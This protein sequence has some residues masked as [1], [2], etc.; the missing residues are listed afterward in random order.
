MAWSRKSRRSNP[1][2]GRADILRP[3]KKMLNI[4]FTLLLILLS[5]PS[6]VLPT[7]ALAHVLDG[8]VGVAD[9]VEV[10]LQTGGVLVADLEGVKT[11]GSGL[12][13]A[14]SLAVSVSLEVSPVAL[15]EAPLAVGVPWTPAPAVV[16]VVVVVVVVGIVAP[17]PGQEPVLHVPV[18]HPHG[19]R[20]ARHPQGR[21]ADEPC[22][23]S[24]PQGLLAEPLTPVLADPAG[25]AGAK[26]GAVARRFVAVG[27]LG[28]IRVAV[29]GH[30]GVNEAS[31]AYGCPAAAAACAA[32]S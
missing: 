20:R 9:E 5:V 14:L 12:S 22:A 2:P 24:E 6:H 4:S 3:L 27:V 23:N 29:T 31:A 11:R 17:P 25:E 10:H 1:H 13:L 18:V 15:T 26:L 16:A 8:Q 21:A 32:S 7:L 28:A 19:R 30:L